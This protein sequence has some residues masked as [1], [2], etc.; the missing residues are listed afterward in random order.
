MTQVYGKKIVLL[1]K[2]D[3]SNSEMGYIY[4]QGVRESS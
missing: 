2:D 4:P 1:T 3:A